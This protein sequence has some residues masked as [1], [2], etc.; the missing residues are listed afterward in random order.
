[1]WLVLSGVAARFSLSQH[2]F[3]MGFRPMSCLLAPCNSFEAF[4]P[5]S[6]APLHIF[7]SI[8]STEWFHLACVAK[9][10]ITF[11]LHQAGSYAAVWLSLVPVLRGSIRGGREESNLWGTAALFKVFAKSTCSIGEQCFQLVT[12]GKNRLPLHSNPWGRRF[13]PAELAVS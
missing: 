12:Q 7:L 4:V 9:E 2:P 8:C 10:H 11:P 5:G 3:E 6:P 13:L 1:M